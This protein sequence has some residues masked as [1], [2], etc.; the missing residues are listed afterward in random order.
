MVLEQQIHLN[1]YPPDILKDSRTLHVIRVAPETIKDIMVID[2]QHVRNLREGLAHERLVKVAGI[3]M[4]IRMGNILLVPRRPGGVLAVLTTLHA[5]PL[6]EQRDLAPETVAVDLIAESQLHVE[7]TALDVLLEDVFPH[8]P[9]TA[10]LGP[11][12]LVGRGR[13]VVAAVGDHAPARLVPAGY[14]EFV[15]RAAEVGGHRVGPSLGARL[16]HLQV[17][18][19]LVEGPALVGEDVVRDELA[20]VGG[21]VDGEVDVDGGRLGRVGHDHDAA[22][23]D[24]PLEVHV[25]VPQVRAEVDP[26]GGHD[27]VHVHPCAERGAGEAAHRGCLGGCDGHDGFGVSG[28]LRVQTGGSETGLPAAEE[29]R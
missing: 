23:P 21:E 6:F 15:A 25:Y 12:V 4:E 7:P 5:E 13:E 9:D 18:V 26:V 3:I 27:L 10:E 20:G 8:E 11:F 2:L 19:V 24:S 28:G 14:D 29:R 16:G 22:E 17:D 1:G